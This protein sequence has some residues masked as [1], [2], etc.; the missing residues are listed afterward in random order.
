M[1]ET[2]Q[3]Q[4][5][6]W[7]TMAEQASLLPFFTLQMVAMMAMFMFTLMGVRGPHGRSI[8]S[9]VLLGIVFGVTVYLLTALVSD[10]IDGMLKPYIRNEILFVAALVGG[11]PAGLICT[12]LAYVARLQFGGMNLWD[13]AGL[14]C[15]FFML[16][17]ALMHPLMKRRDLLLIPWRELL[18]I[19]IAFC[20]PS[21]LGPL[22][23]HW[24]W[25]EI[26]K[27]N[28]YLTM[29]IAR[30]LR[31]PVMLGTLLGM[32]VLIKLDAQRR[33]YQAL[34]LQRMGTEVQG[35]KERERLFMG[36]SHSL[37]TPLTR[38]RL[39]AEL[40][41][42]PQIKKDFDEDLQELESMV[43]A[44]L[45]SL[46]GINGQEELMATRLD[47]LMDRLASRPIYIDA[48]V[49]V[50]GQPLTIWA[51][52]QAIERAMGNLL[53]NG[54]LYGKRVVVSLTQKAQHACV[55]LRDFGPG[56][57]ESEQQAV[58]KPCVRLPHAQET[59]KNGSGL[60]LGIT[61]DIIRAHG[62]DLL[63]RNHPE[64]GLEVTVQ[65]PLRDMR[66]AGA[67]VSA[68]G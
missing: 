35:A 4:A 6:F 32:L 58:F 16:A 63:M 57:P 24:V 13:L 31:F 26:I 27:Q 45:D 59:N 14:E 48:H 67:A 5:F 8:P 55:T 22:W 50:S 56:I 18:L 51:R 64:G 65:L 49:E 52:P 1:Q 10:F 66:T 44:S 3:F 30:A 36:I 25:P 42:E 54:I 40:L 53:D 11:W 33:R 2:A 21:F 39:R 38:L 7:K 61:R 34:E 19:S 43:H 28:T 15:I 62:G 17:G 60:G 68:V 29:W 20:V 9:A 23:F 47:M 41:D 37:K 46:R 12:V